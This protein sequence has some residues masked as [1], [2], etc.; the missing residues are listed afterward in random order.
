MQ[1]GMI[2]AVISINSH[3]QIFKF[4]LFLEGSTY[5]FLKKFQNNLRDIIS[6][7]QYTCDFVFTAT[8]GFLLA[9]LGLANIV[10]PEKLK[11]AS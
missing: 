2:E 4:L 10:D 8:A 7:I 9:L 1:R 5:T 3:E 6:R 11:Q